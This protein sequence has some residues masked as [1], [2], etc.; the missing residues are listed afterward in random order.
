MAEFIE[1]RTTVEGRE[2]A[3]QLAHSIVGARLAAS[4]EI[5]ETTRVIRWDV[6]IED[7]A[8][9]RLTIIT[10]ESLFPALRKH[11]LEGQE[12]ENPPLT[13][14]PLEAGSERYREWLRTEI[15]RP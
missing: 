11:I 10:T 8:L 4:V 3:T 14:T 7:A 1:V 2:A 13:T 9:W 12:D 15:D 5:S 6:G